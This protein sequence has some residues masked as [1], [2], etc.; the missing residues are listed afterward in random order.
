MLCWLLEKEGKQ[1][2]RIIRWKNSLKSKYKT[3]HEI[4]L[5]K[6]EESNLMTL[7]RK[8]WLAW[9]VDVNARKTEKQ[10]SVDYDVSLRFPPETGEGAMSEAGCEFCLHQSQTFIWYAVKDWTQK[11]TCGGW[12]PSANFQRLRET[13]WSALSSS[14]LQ[15]ESRL[16]STVIIWPERK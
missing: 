6:Q 15:G 16:K 7:S 12:V 9:R 13:S 1:K 4:D 10:D 3:K 2:W 8:C 11:K 5:A 14:V